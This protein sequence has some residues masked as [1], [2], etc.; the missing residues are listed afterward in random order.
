VALAAAV[1][2]G[3]VAAAALANVTVYRNDFSSRTEARALDRPSTNACVKSWR[4]GQEALGVEVKNGPRTCSFRLPVEGAE[5]MPDHDLTV[6]GKLLGETP[7]PIRDTAYIAVLV[8]VGGGEFYELRVFPKGGKY[9]LRRTPDGAGFPANGTDAAIKGIG[10]R[11][12]IR[13]EV[14]G[15]EVRALVNGTELASVTDADPGEIEGT[16]L[17]LAVGNTGSTRKDTV[18]LFDDVKVAVPNP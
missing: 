7:R 17:R 14:F 15:A 3:V 11:N 6:D 9:A 5:E 8:R 2:L 10:K 4:K 16:K 12:R 13:L 18:A 1:A